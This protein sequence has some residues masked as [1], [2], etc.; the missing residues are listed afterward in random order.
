MDTLSFASPLAP[1]V[2]TVKD[3]MDSPNSKR[4]YGQ[5]LSDFLAWAEVNE[6]KHFNRATVQR[7]KAQLVKNGLSAASINLAISAIRKLALE[8]S[9][10]GLIS[11]SISKGIIDVE[12]I[13]A[14]GTRAGNWMTKRDAQALLNAPDL[15]TLKGLRDR[16]ILAVL[17]GA[18]LRRSEVAALSFKHLKQRDSRWVIV[19]LVGKG[20]RVRSVP[21]PAWTK[22]AIDLWVKAAKLN[23]GLVFRSI[24]KGGLLGS[25]VSAQGIYN[26]V[27]EYA[28][29]LAAH[30]L[31]R[32]FAKL[33]KSGGSEIDQIQLSL[34]HASISTT[35]K[36][37]GLEQNLTDA[38][39]DHVGLHLAN[40]ETTRFLL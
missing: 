8:S 15:T 6:Y 28:P 13:K 35:E 10:N 4:A 14:H 37:L 25:E 27:K 1:L 29:E 5:A 18:G 16:A 20:N 23:D 39:C 32:T 9:Y 22:A 12:G 3:A 33:A 31:R 17:L 19:D 24:T 30:D 7:Y 11:P 40:S 38:P 26:V 2:Q 36:Y 21:I 34:G